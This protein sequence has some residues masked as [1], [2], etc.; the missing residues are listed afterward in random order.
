MDRIYKHIME[1]H[2]EN[3][4]QMVFLAGPRQ[5]GKTTISKTAKDLTDNYVYLNWDFQD[6]QRLILQG[7]KSIVDEY[8]L[9][10]PFTRK[11]I[12]TLD[13]IHKLKDW[14][15]YLKGFYDKYEELVRFIITGSSKLDIYRN[16][17]DSL[18]GRYFPYR[19]HPFSVREL[20]ETDLVDHEIRNPKEISAEVFETLIEFG[21]FPE[22]FT[23]QSKA[24]YRRWVKLRIEQLFHID[25]RELT[26]IHEIAQMKLLATILQNQVCDP[27][28]YSSLASLVNVTP[29]T[30]TVW[31]N[32]LRSFYYCFRISPWTKNIV[33]SLVKQ[34]KLYLW[35]WA[36]T[37]DKGARYENMVASHLL[38]AIHLWEDRGLG[39]YA[40]FYL[41]DREKRE[42]DFL[43]TK[44]GKPWF[45]V[46]VK[47]SDNRSISEHLYYFQQ[48]TQAP[49]A[50]QVTFNMP[51]EEINCFDY[52]QPIIVPAITFLSQLV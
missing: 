15:N 48:Q 7:P 29:K 36:D 17:G 50:F 43:V 2:L 52:T 39:E 35:N 5:V 9:N 25:I 51:Y 6:D 3:D 40:L 30:I 47:S 26:R 24:F 14:R 8:G 41:R 18:M 11:S 34:P 27:A 28:N 45:L 31:I 44:N 16:A 21:G 37:E 1:N 12:L 19:I 4:R 42:V 33:R 32:A 20:I 13:E 38:K 10:K 46:E 49:H 22:P 23:K